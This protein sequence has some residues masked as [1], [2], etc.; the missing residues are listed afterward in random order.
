MTETA[1]TKKVSTE[2]FLCTSETAVAAI[3][4]KGAGHA[5][6]VYRVYANMEGRVLGEVRFQNG[7]IR[8]VG[9]NGMQNEDLLMIVLDRLIGFQT[10]E[11][12]CDENQDALDL[13]IDACARLNL[14]TAMR[15][16]RNVEGTNQK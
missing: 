12:A 1:E 4:K 13:L 3:D 11:F 15:K 14:R 10:G 16:A 6:H 5:N 9:V 8:E 7:P 2:R